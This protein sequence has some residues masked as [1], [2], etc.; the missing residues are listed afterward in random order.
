MIKIAVVGVGSIGVEHI[1]AINNLSGCE[2]CA[3][4][5]IDEKKVTALSQKYNIPYFTD[6][7]DIPAKV[8]ADAVILNLPH[9]MHCESSIFFLNSGMHVLIEKPMANTLNE[10]DRM[11][12]AAEKSG[13]K[14][15][16]G[17]V[18][19]FFRA[20]QIIKDIIKSE[21]YGR[22]CMYNEI[23]TIDYFDKNRPGWFLSKE[24][25][26]GGI[27]MNYGAHSLDKLFYMTGQYDPEAFASCGNMKNDF[28][29]EGH[30][31]FFLRF[32][33][34][35]SAAVT[36][37]GY[38]VS[39][40]STIYYFTK[41]ALCLKNNDALWCSQNG[42][43]ERM[44]VKEDGLFMERQIMEFCKYISNKPSDIAAAEY[45]RAVIALIEKIYQ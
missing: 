39:D 45:G 40:Y 22:L 36:F 6:Y 16:V 18:Q 29:I 10:C 8:D 27:V 19:R 21:R 44:E 17:H 38:G 2:M 24:K 20:N 37:S 7:H 5:D 12:R 28:D 41:G 1:K 31:Q 14:L 32:R 3:L 15:A 25:A 9:N 4:C 11:I 34:G 33:D 23:R 42:A 30:A 26:G 43:W 13:K 35:F